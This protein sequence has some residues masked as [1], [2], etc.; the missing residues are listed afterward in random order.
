MREINRAFAVLRHSARAQERVAAPVASDTN[1]GPRTRNRFFGQ[2]LGE[3]DIQEI[4]DSI[5][6]PAYFA[7]FARYCFWSGSLVVGGFLTVM[8]PRGQRPRTANVVAGILLLGAAA[9]HWT[10]S[11]W[12]KERR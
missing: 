1:P 8:A 3:P 9:A 11:V 4:T 10:Y 12:F 7:A 6:S 2:R 5:G